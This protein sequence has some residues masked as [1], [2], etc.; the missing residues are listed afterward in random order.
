MLMYLFYCMLLLSSMAI[1]DINSTF[2]FFLLFIEVSSDPITLLHLWKG[3]SV[4]R[5][6]YNSFESFF[7]CFGAF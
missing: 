1:K 7:H 2:F 4:S 3:A 6:S 5:D